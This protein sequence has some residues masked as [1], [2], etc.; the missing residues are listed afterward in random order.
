MNSPLRRKN[1][2]NKEP[3]GSTVVKN[4][5][6]PKTPVIFYDYEAA[7]SQPD[8]PIY[9][10]VDNDIQN[11]SWSEV[12][13]ELSA[14]VKKQNFYVRR[15]TSVIVKKRGIVC[16][17]KIQA[18]KVIKT[19]PSICNV[20]E[21]KK[22][23]ISPSEIIRNV[24]DHKKENINRVITNRQTSP[25]QDLMHSGDVPKVV[26][27]KKSFVSKAADM[28]QE[29]SIKM[30]TDRKSYIPKNKISKIP[31]IKP[32]IKPNSCLPKHGESHV[33]PH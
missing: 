2:I 33:Y 15:K 30:D 26:K 3:I 8:I 20:A 22:E 27:N 19:D 12:S 1:T 9:S 7:I 4:K 21:I 29:N 16:K 14:P 13:N 11:A 10:K 23:S 18:K 31:R 24:K 28:I 32:P 17:S 5:P 25:N 6:E